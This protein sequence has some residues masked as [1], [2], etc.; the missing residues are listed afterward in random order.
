[1]NNDKP[2]ILELNGRQVARMPNV[3]NSIDCL[4]LFRNFFHSLKKLR[5]QVN[6]EVFYG[7]FKVYDDYVGVS[8]RIV[9]QRNKKW[10]LV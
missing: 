9:Q 4:D 10:T 8:L 7:G 5:V 6:N 3:D 2:F 1:M